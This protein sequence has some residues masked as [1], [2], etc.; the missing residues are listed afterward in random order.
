VRTAVS[1]YFAFEVYDARTKL[2]ALRSCHSGYHP[3]PN[4]SNY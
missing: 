2:S 3:T 4:C 1:A